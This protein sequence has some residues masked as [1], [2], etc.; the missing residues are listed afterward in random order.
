MTTRTARP[1]WKLGENPEKD[2]KHESGEKHEKETGTRKLRA[3]IGALDQIRYLT[4]RE[5]LALASGKRGRP[6]MYYTAQDVADIFEISDKTVY[7]N[8]AD[9][10]ARTIC[11]CIRFPKAIIH[12]I[13]ERD[14]NV[15]LQ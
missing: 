13:V 4:E 7:R 5:N 6:S 9:F 14:L 3:P 15:A 12:T 10:H 1:D 11:G 8:Q 2:E